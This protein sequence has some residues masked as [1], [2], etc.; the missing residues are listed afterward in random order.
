[1]I[2]QRPSLLDSDLLDKV[3]FLSGEFERLV[4]DIGIAADHADIVRI[5]R[6]DAQCH[7]LVSQLAALPTD[8]LRVKCA[9]L[10]KRTRDALVAAAQTLERAASDLGR[11]NA[12]DLKVR[13]AY[14]SP[15]LVRF[16]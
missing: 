7:K 4:R 11:G 15:N 5:D 14:A 9:P 6:L 2:S 13:A 10:L 8:R 1:M 3:E 12:R 16:R